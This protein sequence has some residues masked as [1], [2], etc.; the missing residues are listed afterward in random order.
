MGVQY[1][2][3]GPAAGE[4]RNAFNRARELCQKLGDVEQLFWVAYGLQF[5]CMLRMDLATAR[6][7]GMRQLTVAERAGDLAT[8]WRLMWRSGC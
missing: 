8:R 6:E 3:A 1:S 7:L 5:F 4:V 2:R